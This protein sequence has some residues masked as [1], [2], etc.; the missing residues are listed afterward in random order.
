[1]YLEIAPALVVIPFM[2]FAFDVG[3]GARAYF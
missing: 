1:V 2:D 3:L